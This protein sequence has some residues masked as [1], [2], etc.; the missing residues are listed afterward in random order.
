MTSVW[1]RAG[2]TPSPRWGPAHPL[3]HRARSAAAVCLGLA[4][5]CSCPAPRA[6]PAVCTWSASAAAL[7]LTPNLDDDDGDGM[8]DGLGT[9]AAPR[10]DDLVTLGLT[11]GCPP[12][13]V[14]VRLEPAEA[15]DEV[16]VLDRE[17]ALVA[18]HDKSGAVAWS[19]L[20]LSLDAVQGRHGSWSGDATLVLDAS[21]LP[22]LTVS[23]S[24][25]PILR[26]D[27]RAAVVRAHAVALGDPDFA[28]NTT[29]LDGLRRALP[30]LPLVLA[31]QA[32]TGSDRWMQDAYEL[33]VLGGD[34]PAMHVWIELDRAG[35]DQGLFG[36]AEARALA[37]GVGVVFVGAS[38]PTSLNGGGN[39][40]V[41]PVGDHGRWIVGRGH[42]EGARA[43]APAQRAWLDAQGAQG[44]MLE[45]DTDWLET[46]HLDEV[47]QPLWVEGS[48]LVAVSAA[49]RVGL[50]LLR[51]LPATTRVG[52]RSAGAWR[53]D[54]QLLTAHRR[55]DKH[56]DVL[57]ATIAEAVRP[58]AVR[59]IRLPVLFT[60]TPPHGRLTSILPNATNLVQVERTALVSSQ[61][62]QTFD[63]EVRQRLQAAGLTVVPLDVSAYAPHGGGVHCAMLLERD[64]RTPALTP[65][66]T[67]R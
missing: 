66:R 29:F 27:V 21:G 48:T 34:G 55:A 35:P 44:P 16:R 4:A 56:L 67:A 1:G 19:R 64:P 39:L 30:E 42:G 28:P 46:G 63:A 26:P 45:V 33:G 15:R 20:P 12:A 58:L 38:G 36:W 9:R 32:D 7:A 10:D 2:V 51:G 13:A 25:R 40:D 53:S 61:G 60:S 8:R 50:E 23:L 47:F 24:T 65:P 62:V 31:A 49:P 14:Q 22:T 17:G 43:M 37:P 52:P 41:L 6:A 3:E 5:S 54:A 57:E 11:S 59:W 18:G